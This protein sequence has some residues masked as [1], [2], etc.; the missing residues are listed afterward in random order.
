MTRINLVNSRVQ[1]LRLP[2]F[3]LRLSIFAIITLI[4]AN[5]FAEPLPPASQRFADS[6]V[7][8]TPDFQKHVVPLLGRLGCNGRSC[9]GSFQG[10]GDLRLSLFGYDFQMDHNSLTAKS[11]SEQTLRLLV[12]QP[13]ESLVLQKPL[14]QVEHEGG[15]RFAVDSWQHRLLR[16]WIESGAAGV[17]EPQQL[18]RLEVEPAEV[19][20]DDSASPVSL[21]VV[22]VWGNDQRE[23]VT[24][25]CRFRTNDDSVA[26]V[27][28]DGLIMSAGS[29]D[30]HVIVFY[31]NGVASVPVLRPYRS[32]PASSPKT[33]STADVS[34]QSP[35]D[36]F[37][38]KKLGKLSI[39]PSAVCSDS[40]FLRRVSIDL[41]GT[42]P[43]PREVEGFL[44]DTNLNKRDHKIDELLQ[45]P[46]YAAWWANKLCDFTGCNPSQQAELG[47]ETSVQWYMW[48]YERIR[49]NVAYDDIVRRIILAKGRDEGQSYDDYSAEVSSYFRE[50]SP[51]DFAQRTTMPHYW[52]RRCMQKP[53]A[54][55]QAFA[56]NFLGIR[57]QCAECHKHP[58]APWTQ[59]DFREFSRFFETV[60]F[61]VEPQSIERYRELASQVGL[62]VR[63]NNG[64]AVNNDVFKQVQRGRMVPWRELYISSRNEPTTLSLLR[65]GKVTLQQ[66][67]DPRKPIMKWMD[68]PSNPWFAQAFVNRVWASYFNVGIVDPPD[69]LNPANPPS[70]PALLEWLV[71]EFVQHDF[72]MKWLHRQIVSSDTYQR[73]WVPNNT[74]RE[75]RRNF[76]RAVPRRLPAE[77]VYDGVKQA[78]A[79]SDKAD[80]VRSDLSRRAIGHLSMRLAGTYAMQVFG[81]PDRAVNCDCERVNQP[82]LLQAIFLQNDPLVDQ[83]LEDSGW[84]AQIDGQIAAGTA[85]TGESLVKEA[86]LRT[87]SRVPQP[88]ELARG[89][90]CLAEAESAT[91]GLRDL[92]WALINTKE[93][94]LIR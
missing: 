42:L 90:K 83:R 70:N 6:D 4:V 47:Q 28:A 85:P 31:D 54:A 67:D 73:S 77:V 62:S 63:D 60:K 72:D 43:E 30:T 55:A 40:E 56:H 13:D 33:V 5:G 88:D 48:V 84:L 49:E 86:W 45:R 59:D 82:T 1:F 19:V 41:T 52:T 94:V 44:A 79:A 78:V 2:G 17:D 7:T 87:L 76:S 46:A 16:R 64:A 69:D 22:A 68:E 65:S 38:I 80:D 35:I 11:P 18:D 37:V 66:N 24:P 61:G 51:T 50:Q 34:P 10:R 12:K 29:G 20:F 71:D 8:E 14:M 91:Q 74:N 53:D 15:E 93:F 92:L 32:V 21:R 57:L 3:V 26:S 58:F 9:H 89:V 25:L 27:D 23:D 36:G 75:D 81:K 39:T